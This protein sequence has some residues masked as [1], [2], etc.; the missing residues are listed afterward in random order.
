[1]VVAEYKIT[2]AYLK[3]ANRRSLAA[4][5][6][7]PNW[8]LFALLTFVWAVLFVIALFDAAYRKV[9]FPVAVA[10]PFVALLI[11]IV[12]IRRSRQWRASPFY[13]ADIRIEFSDAGIR[14]VTSKSNTTMDWS[15]TT[16]VVHF[17][18]GYVLYFGPALA[19]WIPKSSIQPPSD[20][21]E[22]EALFQAHIA[23]HRVMR[24]ARKR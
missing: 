4:R 6:T 22:L 2:Q 9:I 11:G 24:N 7:F 19:R 12:M 23:N 8:L 3:E 1:M 10:L 16:R 18:D 15:A 17:R 13:Q 5:Q 14:E 21:E 20:A